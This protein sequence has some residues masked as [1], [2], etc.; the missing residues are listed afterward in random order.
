MSAAESRLRSAEAATLLERSRDALVEEWTRRV[1]TG[2]A[3]TGPARDLPQP[4]LVDHMPR[5]VADLVGA[6]RASEVTN[7]PAEAIGRTVWHGAHAEAH[8][9][10]RFRE[11]YALDEVVRELSVFRSTI[12]DFLHAQSRGVEVDVIQLV[13]TAIDEAMAVAARSFE[14]EARSALA[15]SEA[16][17]RRIVTSVADHAIIMLDASGRIRTWNIGAERITGY[18]ADESVGQSVEVFYPPEARAEGRP[19]QLLDRAT[20]EGAAKDAGWRVRKDGSRFFAEVTLTALYDTEGVVCGFSKVTRDVTERWRHE[21]ELRKSRE[22][23]QGLIDH[24]PALV[25]VKDLDGRYLLTNTRFAALLAPSGQPL[26]GRDD[27]EIVGGELGKRLREHDLEVV[28]ADRAIDREEIAPDGTTFLVSRFP[29]R[30]AEQHTFATAAIATDITQRKR[31]ERA[32]AAREQRLRDLFALAP[33]GIAELDPATG[34]MTH[35]NPRLCSITGFGE[36]ELRGRALAEL[37]GMQA[38]TACGAAIDEVLHG[39][40]PSVE[41]ETRFVR[42]DGTEVCVRAVLAAFRA[43]GEE[44]AIAIALVEDIESRK[45]LERAREQAAE[46]R[47]RFVGI[48]SH[49]LRNPLGAILSATYLLE[50]KGALSG[51]DATLLARIHRSADSMRA[52]IHDL[53]DYERARAGVAVPITTQPVELCALLDEVVAETRQAHPRSPIEVADCAPLRGLWDPARVQQAITNLLVNA[54]QHGDPHQP[55]RLAAV[56]QE[57]HAV[58]TVWNAGAPIPSAIRDTLFEPF[59]RAQRAGAG[60]GLGLFIV[61][62]IAIAHGGTV[63]VESSVERGTTFRLVL[64]LA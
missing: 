7:V 3:V 45:A 33:I 16:A 13:H 64:P 27:L 32:L 62:E 26:I 20:R 47:E 17:Y 25:A 6:L 42:K 53:L 14:Q 55:V 49:D 56:A 30:D 12:V 11:G 50:R 44:R 40:R 2:P 60:V 35:C 39:Q 21:Q 43:E 9:V 29:V 58:L 59:K 28:K 48:V 18:R 41:H 54:I 15:E 36:D 46:Q 52:L 23:L 8:A 4:H 24:S 51:A 22:L 1:R 38:R 37:A 63:D 19:R 61:R 57:G 34:A 10:Q 5:L 31:I